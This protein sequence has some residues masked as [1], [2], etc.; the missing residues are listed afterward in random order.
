MNR[1]ISAL[2]YE[3]LIPLIIVSLAIFRQSYD[4]SYLVCSHSEYFGLCA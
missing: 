4:D 1:L 3:I 2:R